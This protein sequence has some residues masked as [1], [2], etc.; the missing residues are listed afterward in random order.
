MDWSRRHFITRSTATA[1]A[2]ALPFD[3][4]AAQAARPA[5]FRDLVLICNEDSNTLSVIDPATNAVHGTINLT[6]FDEDP[7]EPFRLA[8]GGMHATPLYHGAIGLHGASPSPDNRFL[9]C[10]GRGSSNLYLI[11]L[12]SLKVVG[13]CP[14]PL[15]GEQTNAVRLSSGILVGR[16]P[17]GPAFTHNAREIW[18]CLRG[19]GRIAIVDTTAALRECN[20]VPAGAV[21]SYLNSLNGPAQ[22]SFSRDG[23]LAFVT[24]HKTAAFEVVE[25]CTGTDGCS[26]PQRRTLVNI[27]EHDPH[28][29]TAFQ[30]LSPD[31]RE[32]WLSHKLADGLTVW[33]AALEPKLMDAIPLSLNARPNQVEFVDNAGGQVAYVSQAR[34]EEMA[35]GATPSSRIAIIDRTAPQGQRVVTGSFPS[36]GREAH[37]LWTNPERTRLYVAHG[38]EGLADTPAAGQAVCS[39]FDVQDPYSPQFLSQIP[40]GDLPLPSG[41]LRNKRSAELVY[42]RTGGGRRT[43][44]T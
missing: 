16:E 44:P 18:V 28:G 29:F 11:D 8:A 26:R 35:T 40:L 20:G 22:V 38:Q 2:A 43:T 33:S 19:E 1:L 15:A 17:H 39:V 13:C 6:S 27:H 7:R 5:A 25:P 41:R 24:S 14:N 32:L 34:V 3:P 42:V 9:A 31:G 12:E 21:R 23:R 30:K 10:T 4:A 37:G 36:H